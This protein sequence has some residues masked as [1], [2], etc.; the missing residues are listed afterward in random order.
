MPL[1]ALHINRY[2]IAAQRLEHQLEQMLIVLTSKGIE[3]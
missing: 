1:A 2:H 3:D